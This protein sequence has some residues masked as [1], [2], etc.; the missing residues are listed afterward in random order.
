M[1]TF[2]KISYR[3]ECKITQQINCWPGFADSL[4]HL[5]LLWLGTLMARYPQ[6]HLGERLLK[7]ENKYSIFPLSGVRIFFWRTGDLCFLQIESK[8]L[9][10]LICFPQWLLMWDFFLDHIWTRIVCPLS[11]ILPS[12]TEL[13]LLSG[14]SQPGHLEKKSLWLPTVTKPKLFLLAITWLAK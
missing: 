12:L 8:D 2:R 11:N 9:A 7:W 5:K 14:L 13:G 4:G 10:M 6:I 1:A 3:S